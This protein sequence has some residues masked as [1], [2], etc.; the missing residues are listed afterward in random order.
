MSIDSNTTAIERLVKDLREVHQENLASIT[1]YGSSAAGDQGHA[2]SDHNV[3]VVLSHITA[4][5]L[6]LLQPA[7]QNW[8]N[9]GQPTPVFLT[10]DELENGADVFP[11]EFLQMERARKVLYGSDPFEFVEISSLNLRHQTEYELRTRL[12]QLRRLYASQLA[13]AANV[14]TLMIDSFASFAALFRAVLILHGREAPLL[15]TDAVRATVSLLGLDG[16]PFEWILAQR[17]K[18]ASRPPDTEVT[19][20][21]AA[22][23]AQI[24]QVIDVVDR[25]ERP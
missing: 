15:N 1:L 5:D 16:S 19:V 25:L 14:T 7:V 18:K 2:R 9:A 21:Y 22:Y 17:V 24:Q 11:I 3:L 10:V 13:S 12:I 20:V 8:R 6:R 4:D 23:L